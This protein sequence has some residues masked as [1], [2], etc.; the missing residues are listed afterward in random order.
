MNFR[1]IVNHF[2]VSV[3]PK[4]FMGPTY[5]TIICDICVLNL[6]SLSEK[7]VKGAWG[8][9]VFVLFHLELRGFSQRPQGRTAKNRSSQQKPHSADNICFTLGSRRLVLSPILGQGTLRLAA[10]AGV[11]RERW[12]LSW[13]MVKH[14]IPHLYTRQLVMS[15]FIIQVN[16][17]IYRLQS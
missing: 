4:S 12:N 1:L 10:A 13:G 9:G 8:G 5:T 2:V 7:E 15:P 3:Y 14:K 17:M 11:I 16:I 6:T